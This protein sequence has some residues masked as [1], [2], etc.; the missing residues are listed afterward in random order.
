MTLAAE[1]ERGRE[2][3]FWN[4]Q[5]W[6]FLRLKNHV[7]LVTRNFMLQF[8]NND[9]ISCKYCFVS[10]SSLRNILSST[11][12]AHES[13]RIRLRTA[14]NTSNGHNHRGFLPLR[15]AVQYRGKLAHTSSYLL[16]SDC[17]LFLCQGV[18]AGFSN[19]LSSYFLYKRT[20]SRSGYG[21]ILVETQVCVWGCTGG[22][23]RRWTKTPPAQ[24]LAME[25]LSI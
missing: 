24:M 16:P 19:D 25:T 9:N 13:T 12:E 8:E 11:S 6:I 7:V 15:T 5:R 18:S 21:T 20:G 10:D 2:L 17:S 4:W 23:A 3:K 1:K 14:G 22:G